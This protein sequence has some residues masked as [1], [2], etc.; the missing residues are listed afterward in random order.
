MKRFLIDTDICIY[1]MK[2]KFGLENRAEFKEGN[3]LF[4]SEITVA[5]LKFGVENSSN[6]KA[7]RQVL[8][9]FLESFQIIPISSAIDFYTTEK[10]KLRKSG[11]SVDD[12][13]LLIGSTAISNNF[14]LVKNNQKHF[15][16]IEGLELENWIEK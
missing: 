16:K 14:I 5:E 2:G 15:K 10:A 4:L 6:V 12:F 8:D 3:S 1:Y 13:D 9:D 11:T 7:N